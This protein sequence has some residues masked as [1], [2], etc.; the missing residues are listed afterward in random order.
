MTDDVAVR[1]R[2]GGRS[3]RVRQSV[4][5]ATL[6]LLAERGLDGLTVAEVAELAGVHETSIR[7]RWQTRENLAC[8]AMLNYSEQQLPIPDTGSLREDLA[9]FAAEIAAYDSTPLG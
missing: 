9:T 7:R 8:D 6:A 5:D 4:L 1:R 2:P 3:A